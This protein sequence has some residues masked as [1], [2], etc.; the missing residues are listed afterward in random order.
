MPAALALTAAQIRY[1]NK[2]FWRNPASAFFIFALPLIFLVVFTALLGQDTV[3]LG[4]RQVRIST[5]YVASMATFSVV[6]A[7]FN[8]IAISLAFQRDQGVLKR[9]D[10]TPM[11][12]AVY[13]TARV[14]HALLVS[15]LLVAITAGFGKVVCHAD[16]PAAAALAPFAAMLAVGAAAFCA[17]GFAMTVVI[18]N[19]DAAA[20]L[21]NATI[22]PLMFLSGVFIPFG[23]HTPRWLVWL[24]D[25]FPVKHFAEGMQAG[26][27]GSSFAWTDLLIVAAWGAVGLAVALRW[28]RWQPRT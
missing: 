19:A 24:A 2:A 14:V 25:V 13:L 28:F 7:C 21:V 10:G 26:F 15:L 20:P 17:L 16:L 5:Y 18:P 6:T 11:P 12:A 4:G 1:V 27:L 9:V 22:L 23:D 8:N 3:P